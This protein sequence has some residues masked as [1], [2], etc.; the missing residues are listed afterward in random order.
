MLSQIQHLNLATDGRYATDAE[1]QFLR[2]YM[3]SYA[4]RV[5]TYQALQAAEATI[6]Q[7]VHAQLMA[8]DP[9]LL[10]SGA[11]D[12]T[13]KWK[14]DT[15]RVLRYS[16]VAMLLNDPD[17]LQE[18]FLLWFQTIMRAFSAQKS[19]DATYEAMQEV[20]KRTLTPIQ[21]SLVCPI[22]ELN[23]RSLGSTT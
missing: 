2:D 8:A 4:L 1:L 16:S 12:L 20:V 10:S 5:E 23:R 9:T 19:C 7:Q 18:Q 6:V 21:S 14:R 11:D 13:A 3:K 22:L 15:I 17:T